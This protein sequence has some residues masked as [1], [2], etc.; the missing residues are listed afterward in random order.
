MRTVS[1]SGRVFGEIDTFPGCGVLCVSHGVYKVRN[2]PG[3]GKKAHAERL[4]EMRK[5]GYQFAM[6]T[7]VDT[8]IAQ[9]KIMER[10]LWKKLFTFT[11]DKTGND[12]SMWL[13]ALSDEDYLNKRGTNL[14]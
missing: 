1:S 12:V 9:V 11:S 5:L 3:E 14:L 7:V 10:F 13:K 2:I 4:A 8:N 6:C